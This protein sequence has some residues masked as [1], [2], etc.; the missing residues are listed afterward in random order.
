MCHSLPF[1]LFEKT[2]SWYKKK[3][4]EI[5]FKRVKRMTWYIS[6]SKSLS[7]ENLLYELGSGT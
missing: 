4:S 1:Y 3:P 7:F 6:H 5:R 2:E